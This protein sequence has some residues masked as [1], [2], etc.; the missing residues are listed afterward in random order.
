MIEISTRD[1]QLNESIIR[2]E[3]VEAFE[4]FYDEEVSMQENNEEPTVTKEANRKRERA[5]AS[6]LTHC[7]FELINSIVGGNVSFS[8]W[9]MILTFDSDQQRVWNQVA[10]RAWKNGKVLHERFFY[11]NSR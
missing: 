8:Q 3:R 6:R 1:R 5:F 7:E 2:G 11:E 9:K 10:V 4:E